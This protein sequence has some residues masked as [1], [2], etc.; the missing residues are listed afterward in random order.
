[1]AE[2]QRLEA[3][4]AL[5]DGVSVRVQALTG[6]RGQVIF[7]C[8]GTMD[9]LVASGYLTHSMISA[10]RDRKRGSGNPQLDE[11]GG[12]FWMQPSPSKISPE[13]TML[14]RRMSAELAMRLPGVRD[15]FPEGIP[16]LQRQFTED[17]NEPEKESSKHELSRA[18]FCTSMLDMIMQCARGDHPSWPDSMPAETQCRIERHI[19][20]LREEFRRSVS[21]RRAPSFLRLVVDNTKGDS[22]H[23]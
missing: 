3:H 10:R 18:D 12:R 7:T 5:P 11:N 16:E 17:C 20:V 4:I 23:G 19:D 9:A 15:L 8:R 14:V 13:R 2:S 1:M 21:N 22:A 6:W